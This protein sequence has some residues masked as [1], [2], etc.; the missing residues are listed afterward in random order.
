MCPDNT[1]ASVQTT[2]TQASRQHGRKRPEYTSPTLSK[3]EE[4]HGL[5][6]LYSVFRAS[7]APSP[8]GEGGGEV[9]KAPP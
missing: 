8:V 5:G 4:E 1:D 7:A 6:M 9:K 3:G 2:R